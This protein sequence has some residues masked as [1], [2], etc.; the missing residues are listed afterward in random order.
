MRR[1]SG[2]AGAVVVLHLLGW[3]LFWWYSRRYGVVAVS[4]V[5][6]AGA[7]IVWRTTHPEERWGRLAD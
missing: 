2:F 4:V 1:L 3:G 5:T 7:A 6:W